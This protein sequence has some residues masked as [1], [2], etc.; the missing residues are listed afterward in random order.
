MDSLPSSSAGTCSSRSDTYISSGKPSGSSILWAHL[1]RKDAQQGNSSTEANQL[2]LPPLAP[3][4]KLG[5]STR[6]LLLDTQAHLEK[7]AK[8]VEDLTV[9]VDCAK[10]EIVTVK[11]LFEQDREV[12]LGDFVDKLSR[13]QSEIQKTVGSPAQANQLEDLRKNVELKLE[14]M[15]QRLNSMQMV[16]LNSHLSC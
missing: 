13:S 3:S 6:I 14:S 7:F 1:L 15:D 16:F 10:Q 9:K 4:D 8:S 11:T 12:L 2:P 5:T